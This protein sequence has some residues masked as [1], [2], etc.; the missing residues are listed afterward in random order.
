MI[1]RGSGAAGV[2]GAAFE[3]WGATID[4]A[5]AEIV[6]LPGLGLIGLDVQAGEHAIT[7]SLGRTPVRRAAEIAALTGFGVWLAIGVWW[8]TRRRRRAVV[9][10]AAGVLL[11]AAGAWALGRP[12][13]GPAADRHT[14]PLVM[15]MGSYPYLHHEPDGLRIGSTTLLDY[16]YNADTLAPGD[17][18]AIDLAWLRPAPE[19]T[20]QLRLMGLSSHLHDQSVDWVEELSA[21]DAT[22]TRVTM[23]LPD[24][25]P[26]GV[27][28]PRVG[29]KRGGESLAIEN[30]RGTL[31]SRTCL[32]PIWV[33]PRAAG[34][35][36]TAPLAE[37]G[38][39]HAPPTLALV[40]A[41]TTGIKG[42]DLELALRW[43]VRQTPRQ[44]YA[45]SVRYLHADGS[46]LKPLDLAPLSPDY[47]TG[48]WRQGELMTTRLRVALVCNED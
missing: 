40:Q 3:G 15:D 30:V 21:V 12:L 19:E 25:L 44:N 33:L 39:P 2:S 37:Y 32:R 22:Q 47:P 26:P 31:Q 36:R 7:L 14:G 41:A 20:L 43:R 23:R 28:V 48:L 13:P 24:D 18:L 42:H 4:G 35:E 8:A 45:I 27:Y 11:V 6:A 5:P 46:T 34:P 10:V 38:D 1:L 16:A 9:S 17:D 29:I